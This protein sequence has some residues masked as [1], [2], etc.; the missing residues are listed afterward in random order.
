VKMTDLQKKYFTRHHSQSKDST[1]EWVSY[2]FGRKFGKI[3]KDIRIIKKI[4]GYLSID[5]CSYVDES[6]AFCIKII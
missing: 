3:A 6:I 1:W 2:V 5:G 4:D